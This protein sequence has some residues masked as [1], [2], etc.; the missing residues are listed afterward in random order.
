[1]ILKIILASIVVASCGLK[2]NHPNIRTVKDFDLD[3]YIGTWYEIA[4]LDNNKYQKGCKSTVAEYKRGKKNKILVHN[5]CVLENGKFKEAIGVAYPVD[6]KRG[7]LKV[8]FFRPFYGRYNVIDVSKDYNYAMVSGK[9]LNSL[10][11]LSKTQ[12]IDG[13]V[14]K[15]FL[16]KAE[17]M[18]FNVDALRY[19]DVLNE[20][21]TGSVKFNF[22][23]PDYALE[24]CNN[25]A[26]LFVDVRPSDYY[27]DG[28][29]PNAINIPAE[30][31]SC[32]MMQY[33]RQPNI[34]FYC[35]SGNKSFD[36]AYKYLSQ[37]AKDRKVYS[38]NGGFEAWKKKKFPMSENFPHSEQ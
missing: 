22:I 14:L 36:V 1:M 5:F 20:R 37:C 6:E 17:M 8:S 29:I 10:W 15:A 23:S 16:L 32:D 7:Q 3:S 34:V 21:L 27:D 31:F 35:N 26:F 30:R 2:N 9:D 4:R 24:E 38:L 28:H 18:G 13:K 25:D 19:E 33:H 11:I 12:M